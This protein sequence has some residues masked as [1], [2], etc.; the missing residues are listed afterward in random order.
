MNQKQRICIITALVLLILAGLIPPVGY[1]YRE[2]YDFV[3]SVYRPAID[4][5]RLFGEWLVVA[6]VAYGLFFILKDTEGSS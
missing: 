2:R 1:F 4:W 5:T 6:V 3:F